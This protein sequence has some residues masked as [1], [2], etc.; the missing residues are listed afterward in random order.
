MGYCEKRKC[1]AYALV[2][3]SIRNTQTQKMA[4]YNNVAFN[5]Y[6]K[7]YRSK[8]TMIY[9]PTNALGNRNGVST[10]RVPPRNF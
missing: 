7:H 1:K 2:L 10:N 8:K 9:K 5:H 6:T 3:P 4:D